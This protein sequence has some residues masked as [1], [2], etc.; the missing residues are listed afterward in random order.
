MFGMILFWILIAG[1]IGAAIG[2]RTGQA[3]GGFIFGVLLG[4]IGWFIT[5]LSTGNRVKCPR[6]CERI[7]SEASI[8][9]KCRS[10]LTGRNPAT[11]KVVPAP[12]IDAYKGILKYQNTLTRRNSPSGEVAPPISMPPPRRAGK[13]LM[14]HIARDGVDWGEVEVA[15]VKQFLADGE[16]SYQD[17]FLDPET[18]S[19]LT[20]DCC[21]ELV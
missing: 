3:I 8:C 6:C 21:R 19:W 14:L 1:G 7:D 5:A 4:P 16:L 13:D 20:L 9:P 12:V 2:N 15:N 11:G 17:H 10:T 18:N